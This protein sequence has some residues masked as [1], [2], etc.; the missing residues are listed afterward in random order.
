MPD[1][2]NSNGPTF[3]GPSKLKRGFSSRLMMLS[4]KRSSRLSLKHAPSLPTSATSPCFQHGWA[5]W[6]HCTHVG[7]HPRICSPPRKAHPTWSM[8]F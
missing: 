1:H 3:R 2:Y 6:E 4:T 7:K 8:L 5:D